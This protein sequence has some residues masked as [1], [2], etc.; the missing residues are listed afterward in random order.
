M[1]DNNK[2]VID[3]NT[4]CEYCNKKATHLIFERKEE[5]GFFIS[6]KKLRLILVCNEHRLNDPEGLG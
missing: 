3:L 6:K 5:N 2:Q 1:S 4:S